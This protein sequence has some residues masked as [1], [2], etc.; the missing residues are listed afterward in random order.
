M[1]SK[2]GSKPSQCIKVMKYSK[3]TSS[4]NLKITLLKKLHLCPSSRS[5]LPSRF[6]VLEKQKDY[7]MLDICTELKL[8][9]RRLYHFATL[10]METARFSEMLVPI[11][12]FTLCFI[13][14]D[15]FS[16]HYSALK[17]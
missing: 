9:P 11:Y 2:M 7:K 14:A 6:A 13:P 3:A 1:L 15:G 12:Q 5:C 16:F 10:Q 17:N 8:V 4:I